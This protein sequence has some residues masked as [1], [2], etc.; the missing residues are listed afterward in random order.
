MSEAL[1]LSPHTLY[2]RQRVLVRSGLLPYVEGRGPG[3]GVRLTVDAVA[4]LLI[5]ILA[6][7]DLAA[8]AEPTRTLAHLK[9]VRPDVRVKPKSL[10]AAQSFKTVISKA[11]ANPE[12]VEIE[13]VN[14]DRTNLQVTISLYE[15]EDGFLEKIGF[16]EFGQSRLP[17]HNH[18]FWTSAHIA[19]SNLRALGSALARRLSADN[20]A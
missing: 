16:A 12:A 9:R 2:E 10:W 7:D 4:M 20:S 11:L 3:S 15:F 1:Q 8:A 6:T 13:M 18:R 5:S 19:G 17:S 14:V